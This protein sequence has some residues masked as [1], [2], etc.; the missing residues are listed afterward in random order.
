MNGL[1]IMD[2]IG[3]ID[4]KYIEKAENSEI[5]KE[6]KIKRISTKTWGLL[7]ASI[8][9]VLL[10]GAIYI[11][12]RNT[13]QAVKH[14]VE[15]GTAKGVYIP[16]AQIPK[17]LSDE[18]MADMIGLVV[19]KGSIY[20]ESEYYDHAEAIKIEPL[21]GEYL[22]QANGKIDEWSEKN[23]YETEFASTIGGDVYSVRGYSTDFRICI[24]NEYP[25]DDGNKRISISF[26][27]RLN[28]I[29]LTTG[30]DLFEDRLQISGNIENITWQS[31]DDWN[32]EIKNYHELDM[33]S[34]RWTE[35][36]NAVDAA[37]FEYLWNEDSPST[38]YSVEGQ[39]HLILNMKDGTQVQ[40]RLIAGGYVG[41]QP[42]GWYF[43]KIPEDIFNALY[44]MCTE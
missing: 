12:S 11:I 38:I 16:A 14:D 23:E 9:L 26:M 39:L 20:I 27:D 2:A 19:Y 1:D 32:Y 43:V 5:K 21:L 7:A 28:D 40:L 25:G 31:H 13:S 41:Y 17:D 3:N 42:L 29:T 24:K 8:C 44:S 6:S 22:G 4:P 37:E 15:P 34:N 33:T 36:M 35:F 30:K 10:V 18:A